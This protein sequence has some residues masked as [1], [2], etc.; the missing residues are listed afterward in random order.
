M[1]FH[2]VDLTARRPANR[3]DAVANGLE[4]V[5][6]VRRFSYDVVFMDLQM[7]E[8]DGIGAMRE[9]HRILPEGRRPR[10]VALTANAFEEDRA[11]CLAAGMDDYLSKPLQ[12]GKLEAALARASRIETRP[13]RADSAAASVAHES[14]GA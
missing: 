3:A 8:L 13:S 11:E 1:D 4:A 6:S 14:G 7:P 10:I 2:D 5:D 12:P 9:I